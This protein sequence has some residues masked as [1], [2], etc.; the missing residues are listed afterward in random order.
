MGRPDL[1]YAHRD[2]D[3]MKQLAATCQLSDGLTWMGNVEGVSR[4][5]LGIV[6]RL[7][8]TCWL[9]YANRYMSNKFSI[10]W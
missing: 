10:F 8:V 7:V 9:G 1:A 2:L 5:N 3:V 4:L 6:E